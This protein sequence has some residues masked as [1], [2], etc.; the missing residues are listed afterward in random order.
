MSGLD[1]PPTIAD[2]RGIMD[3]AMVNYSDADGD[4]QADMPLMSD[5]VVEAFWQS[6]VDQ[7]L[8][9]RVG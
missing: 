2:L 5:A 8:L 7:G 1:Q 6:L 9:G 4:G 3:Q